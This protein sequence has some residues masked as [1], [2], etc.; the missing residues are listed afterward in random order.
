MAVLEIP[1][2]SPAWMSMGAEALLVL[3]IGG[4]AV[5]MLAGAVA[6]FTRK[7]ETVH[8]AAGTMFF[9]AMLTCAGIGAVVSPFLDEGQRPNTVAGV[10]TF[11]LVLTAWTAVRRR[12]GGLDRFALPGFLVALGSALAGVVFALEAQASPTGTIDNTPPQAF[13]L[14]IIAGGVAAATDLKVIWRGG[15]SGAPRIARHLW[16]MCVGLFIAAGSFFLGQPQALPS[17]LRGSALVFV[18]PFLPL[19][20]MVFWLVRVRLTNWAKARQ[21]SASFGSAESRLVRVEKPR[22][23][24]PGG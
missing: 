16:R 17:F 15:I 9:L 4:G 13:A 10:L 8:R 22:F 21:D 3:H 20:L 7:G 23:R 14:F 1:P 6:L 5:A 19:V 2:D 11:Y 24:G 12:D 18:P